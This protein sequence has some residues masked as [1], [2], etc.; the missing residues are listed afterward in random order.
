MSRSRRLPLNTLVNVKR[1]LFGGLLWSMQASQPPAYELNHAEVTENS[2]I[3]LIR[4]T[5][6]FDVPAD[7][8]RRVLNDYNHIY[9]LSSSIIETEV[10]RS[11][12]TSVTRVRTK[13]LACAAVFC[14]EVE[15]VDAIRT[16]ASGDIQAEIIPEQSEFR[17]GR[18]IWRITPVDDK[19]KLVYEATIE[20]DF[21]IP[22]V[23][24]TA[25]I[26]RSLKKEFLASFGRIEHIAGINLEKDWSETHSFAS[27][28]HNNSKRPCNK[29]D[30]DQ[31]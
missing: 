28:E 22:P 1:F 20:P 7:Y 31:P 13:L 5:A 11:N 21:F 19:S 24:G 9:R 18:A 10:L 12:D 15:R 29:N 2:G 25:V 23:V 4:I 16:L 14:Q 17:S 6:T 27:L 30:R 3:F 8:I 26:S